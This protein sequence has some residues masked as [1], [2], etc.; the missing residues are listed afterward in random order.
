MRAE[1]ARL[2]IATTLLFSLS[3]PNA[4]AGHQD[5]YGFGVRG[6]GLGGASIAF[7][8]GF[9]SIYYN[10]AGLV[11]GGE[12]VFSIGFQTT[13]F[14]LG[15]R[16]PRLEEVAGVAE[17]DPIHGVTLGIA[18]RLP[19]LGILKDRIA[20]GLGLYIP[21]QTL[22]S[23]R[24]PRPY[25]P[26][27]SLVGDRA[28]SIAIKFGLGL[29][30]TE[31]LRVGASLRA[32]ATLQGFIK[33]GPTV[34]GSLGS[35]VEDELVASYAA[36]VGVV[37]NPKPRWAIGIVW[38]MA[39]GAKFELPIT[40]DLSGGTGL[41]LEIPTLQI[42]G[43]AVYD[44]QQAAIH[45]GWKPI[46]ELSIELGL[47][48]KHWSAFPL[49]LEN[50]TNA[51]PEQEPLDFSD[52]IVWRI[53][54]ESEQQFGPWRFAARGG[55]T[56]EPT[57]VNEQMGRHTFLDSDRHILSLGLGT[58]WQ[59][60]GR[61]RVNLDVSAQMHFMVP[62]NFVKQL[63]GGDAIGVTAD[64]GFP[65]IGMEGRIFSFGTVLEVQL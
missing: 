13:S 1:K 39:L 54:V 30:L 12:R 27:F 35:E 5:L 46:D 59:S 2:L 31:W 61:F 43:S 22:L 45:A 17:E 65:W 49:P 11:L 19:L 56:Y 26:Q 58:G 9:E 42:A 20:L 6:P 64:L 47:T 10:P 37:I 55:Y 4:Q 16:S 21:S 32:L 53:G 3:A 15:V 57:P 28:R 24:I 40:A 41:P 63:G 34:T 7:P 62:R 38:R 14:D 52:T 23:A 18:V 44:P 25:S 8:R 48:W 29:K 50:T 36:V 51:V 33:V 60:D